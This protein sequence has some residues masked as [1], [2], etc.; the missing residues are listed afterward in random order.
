[1]IFVSFFKF[2]QQNWK[3]P[4]IFLEYGGNFYKNCFKRNISKTYE[5]KY[6]SCIAD[7]WRLCLALKTSLDLTT[8]D[9]HKFSRHGFRDGFP[10]PSNHSFSIYFP[11]ISLVS[12]TPFSER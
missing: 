5:K 2:F 8:I 7:A 3:F 9:Q 12:H 6:A 1:M 10:A 11:C 4:G